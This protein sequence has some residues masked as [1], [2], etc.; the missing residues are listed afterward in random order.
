[1]SK[2]FHECHWGQCLELLV[3]LCNYSDSIILV[4]GPTGIGKTT[5]LRALREQEAEQFVFCDLQGTPGLTSEQLTERIELDLDLVNEKDLLLLIDDAQY[6]GLDVIAMLF[7][8]KQRTADEGRLHIALFATDEFEQKIARSVLKEEFAEQVHAVE[9]E[10]LTLLETESFLRHHWGLKH[11]ENDIPFDKAKC[12]KI[13]AL[14]GGLPGK[15]LEVIEKMDSKAEKEPGQ[16]SLSPFTVGVTVSFGIL[17]CILAIL[18]PSADKTIIGK[19]ETTVTEQPLQLAKDEALQDIIHEA[20]EIPSE[21]KMAE[22]TTTMDPLPEA[23]IVV[24]QTNT[25]SSI[26]LAEAPAAMQVAESFDEKIANLEKKVNELQKQVATEQKALRATESKL[27]QLLAKHQPEATK[28]TSAKKASSSTS[29][30][31]TLSI[32]RQEKEILALPGRNYTLQLLSMTDET[33]VKK[34]I[35]DHNLLHKAN[36][37]KTNIKGKNWFV[38]VYGNY[39]NKYDAQ[40]AL[41][42]LPNALK[43]LQPKT[44]EYSDIQQAINRGK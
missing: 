5:M 42:K 26:A 8:L 22:V 27:Q 4:T 33:K 34:F 3:H 17:F 41:A 7:Q 36:Y 14:S 30:V 43:K 31:K 19:N 39:S 18:W 21:I 12:K 28:K 1:M 10:P 25:A 13:H 37:Y 16:Q 40:L 44:R 2:Y 11:R 15:I 6:L 38:L 20:A 9:I 24:A 23:E 32:S 35:S 29:T